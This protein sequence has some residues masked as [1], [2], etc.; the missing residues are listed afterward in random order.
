MHQMCCATEQYLIRSVVRCSTIDVCSAAHSRVILCSSSVRPPSQKTTH[1][2]TN[3]A[4][5]RDV[6]HQHPP[7]LHHMLA[8]ASHTYCDGQINVSYIMVV[9]T[10]VFRPNHIE[11]DNNGHMSAWLALRS[12]LDHAHRYITSYACVMH[13]SAP[14]CL[15]FDMHCA[16]NRAKTSCFCNGRLFCHSQYCV[17][18]H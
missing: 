11:F 2:R 8:L 4:I 5:S 17:L 13:Q 1:L 15:T 6:V 10:C 18:Q 9:P 14:R 3:I 16:R 7:H 12:C